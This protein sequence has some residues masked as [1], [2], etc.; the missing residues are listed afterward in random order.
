M[1]SD[2]E[3]Q[4]AVLNELKWDARVR[5]TDVGVQVKAG[6]VALTGTLG[7]WAE[8]VAAREAAHRVAGVLDVVN[9]IEVKISGNAE[10]TDIEIAHALRTALEWDVLVPEAR[11]KSTVSHGVITLEGEV[12]F[13]TQREDAES[14]L[15]NLSG[16]R[17][18]INQLQVKPLM[19]VTPEEVKAAIIA[20]LE[21]RTLRELRHIDLGVHDGCVCLSG[22]VHSW[23]ERNA[24]VGAA[25]S[26]PGVLRV[27]D[28]LRIE[29]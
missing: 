11:I 2:S 20:A 16:V 22:A 21:R 4:Q 17:Q 9:D 3:I 18:I 24:A 23:A 10:K 13:G 26:T 27:E 29:P 28:H 5:E 8:R 14:A 15:R 1:R 6:V 7:S 25:R 19:P 12:D